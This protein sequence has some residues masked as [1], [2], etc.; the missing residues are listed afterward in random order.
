MVFLLRRCVKIII[1]IKLYQKIL[2]MITVI[3]QQQ[4][5]VKN[6]VGEVPIIKVRKKL[7]LV[8]TATLHHRQEEIIIIKSN[9]L[10]TVFS[11]QVIPSNYFAQIV[12]KPHV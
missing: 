12:I 9:K 10:K 3:K 11:T 5:Q 6:P 2:E 7:L 8:L 4:S 1:I